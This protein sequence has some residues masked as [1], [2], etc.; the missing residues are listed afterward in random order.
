VL[1][2]AT[3]TTS[4]EIPHILRNDESAVNKMILQIGALVPACKEAALKDSKT[5]TDNFTRMKSA[6][7]E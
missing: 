7:Y 2:R 1:R 4:K 5:L 3:S 6:Y